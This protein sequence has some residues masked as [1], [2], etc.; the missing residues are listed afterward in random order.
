MLL[1]T[2]VCSARTGREKRL[3]R[4]LETRRAYR[5]RCEGCCAAWFAESSDGTPTF[6]VQAIF[7]DE[8][9]WRRISGKISEELDPIDGGVE[10]CLNGPP[11]VG[12]FEIQGISELI[13]D[14]L[15]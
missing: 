5:L 10:N 14:T 3:R 8:E 9:A 7:E 12:M 11:L 1:E 6:L 13:P 2:V 4:L 15:E